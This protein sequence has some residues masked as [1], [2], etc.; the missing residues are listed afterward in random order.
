[1][2]SLD[3]TVRARR[4]TNVDAVAERRTSRHR[5]GE[6]YGATG[7]RDQGRMVDVGS[8]TNGVEANVCRRAPVA[9]LTFEVPRV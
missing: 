2:G 8:R 4:G 7:M 6:V 5:D 3:T 9:P 1:M